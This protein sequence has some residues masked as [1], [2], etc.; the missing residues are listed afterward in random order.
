MSR[1][2]LLLLLADEILVVHVLFV[3]FVVF[4]LVAVYLGYFLNWLWV[5]NLSFR[6]LHLLAIG[7]VVL[8]SWLGVICPLT[9]WANGAKKR[10]WGWNLCWLFYPALVTSVVV[11]HCARLGIY[12]ALQRF[13]VIGVGKLVF[14]A[15]QTTFALAGLD[16]GKIGASFLRTD[17]EVYSDLL[18][19]VLFCPFCR[20]QQISAGQRC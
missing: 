9:I 18:C 19:F 20:R 14:G 10:S 12:T 15:T 5:R 8:Q 4:G 17:I 1:E 3:C 2:L 6:L 11:L 13:W 7:I 16:C